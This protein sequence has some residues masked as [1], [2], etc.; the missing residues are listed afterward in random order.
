MTAKASRPAHRRGWR[1]LFSRL[2][3]FSAGFYG[4]LG[5]RRPQLL[6]LEELRFSY[7]NQM[8]DETDPVLIDR[9]IAVSRELIAIAHLDNPRRGLY[10]GWLATDLT[11]RYA[12]GTR[13]GAMADLDEAIWMARAAVDASPDGPRRT[14]FMTTLGVCLLTSAKHRGDPRAFAE[15]IDLLVASVEAADP[16]S[17][18]HGLGMDA[19]CET[20]HTCVTGGWDIDVTAGLRTLQRAVTRLPA[21]APGEMDRLA[22]L[23][24]ALCDAVSAG[25][26]RALLDEA[27]SLARAVLA[28]ADPDA[29]GHLANLAGL[30][31][32]RAT[33]NAE[34]ADLAESIRLRQEIARM[35]PADHP[36]FLGRM[37]ALGE[38]QRIQYQLTGDAK[39]LDEALTTH[40]LAL[41]PTANDDPRR[42]DNLA[43]LSEAL[44]LRFER[45]GDRADAR[46]AV[47]TARQALAVAPEADGDEPNLLNQLA[48]AL[49][50]SFGA[51]AGPSVLSEAIE[52]C[53]RAERIAA[54]DDPERRTYLTN[55]TGL[56]TSRYAVSERLQDAHEAVA[57]GRRAV[58]VVRHHDEHTA[59][60]NT[61][62]A[63]TILYSAT[64]D[65]DALDEAI[66]VGRM[67]IVATRAA[68]ASRALY[69]SQLSDYL[70]K[71]FLL[72]ENPVDLD[73]STDLARRAVRSLPPGAPA[74]LPYS[75]GLGAA[76]LVRSDA[77]KDDDDDALRE[78]VEIYRDTAAKVLADDPDRALYFIGLSGCL[79]SWFQRTGD[80]TVLDEGIDA[81]RRAI[82]LGSEQAA[83]RALGRLN[84]SLLLRAR[85]Q[86]T[87]IAADLD[88]ALDLAAETREDISEGRPYYVQSRQNHGETLA[89]RFQHS[90]DPGDRSAAVDAL[91]QALTAGSGEVRTRIDAGGRLAELA[92]DSGDWALAAEALGAAVRWLPQLAPRHFRRRD[93]ERVLTRFPGLASNAAAAA[94][95]LDRPELAVE[96]LELGRGILISQTLDVRS[97]LTDLAERSPEL[98]ARLDRLRRALDAPDDLRAQTGSVPVAGPGPSLGHEWDRLVA[99][100]R[101]LPGMERFLMPPSAAELFAAAEGGPVVIVNAGLHRSDALLLGPASI[102]V[103]PLPA[104]TPD[105]AA[106]RATAFGAALEIAHDEK[107]G[108]GRRAHAEDDVRETLAW[109]WDTVAEPILDALGIHGPPEEGPPSRL[110][111]IP[112]GPLNFLPLHAAGHHPRPGTPPGGHRSVLDR[113]TSSYAPTLRALLQAR[114]AAHRPADERPLVVAVPDATEHAPL[115]DV[116]AEAETAAKLLPGGHTLLGAEAT[117][118]GVLAAMAAST[119]VHFACHG[120]GDPG[121]PSASHLVLHDGPLSVLDVGGLRVRH[122]EFA[123]LSACSTARG[124]VTLADEA[125]H[126]VTAFH[127]A[128]YRHVI[129]TMWPVADDIARLITAELYATL[130]PA[131]GPRTEDSSMALH[132]AV[133]EVRQ[134]WPYTPS[135]WAAWIHAGS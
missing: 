111:W 85:F 32:T 25:P 49:W 80:A 119:W 37:F 20:L 19:L 71:R 123:L 120:R 6:M 64:G 103:V 45:D 63:L 97:E 75:L 117:R 99:E 21:D 76:L 47:E 43:G 54:A 35:T 31:Y 50:T 27:V 87:G 74:V 1:R 57:A 26:H 14:R 52:L 94:L 12:I 59:L 129:G 93:Q 107:A 105:A 4:L 56:L 46:E 96:L 55:L 92:A 82:D 106:E 110:W 72:Y 68:P 104:L 10:Q 113:V 135:M 73:E 17:A 114:K 83:R 101:R 53:R 98:A 2:V 42:S 116:Q 91:R 60:S 128:G 89:A 24:N 38:A 79:W 84:L 132:A 15:T 7:R 118:E 51:G 62:R 131:G 29:A 130:R 109:L 41:E 40:A 88:E 33:A 121:E 102:D 112:T 133:Q 28:R 125:I 86:A 18:G 44:R 30:L 126:L 48:L 34:P 5:L 16:G 22:W 9:V 124:A 100:I 95:H 58:A 108:L 8:G 39:T 36:D 13:G 134:R 69:D 90:G 61:A 66:K 23:G 127:L 65:L 3:R 122:G 11:A 115:H 67:T 81:A 70:L 77:G 78:A